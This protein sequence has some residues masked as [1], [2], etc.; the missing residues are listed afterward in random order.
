[1]VLSFD[2]SSPHLQYLVGCICFV[3][4]EES[5]VHHMT[6]TL[7]VERQLDCPSWWCD[8]PLCEALQGNIFQ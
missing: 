5:I 3:V 4:V 2:L 1:M 8:G 7:P 6:C